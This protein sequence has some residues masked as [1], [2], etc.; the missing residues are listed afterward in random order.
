MSKILK[1]EVE[2]LLEKRICSFL[3]YYSVMVAEDMKFI[4][5]KQLFEKFKDFAVIMKWDYPPMT[6][7]AFRYRCPIISKCIVNRSYS[8]ELIRERISF[9]KNKPEKQIC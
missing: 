7:T 2:C 4:S 5:D 9:D 1:T 3:E 6:T 8:I